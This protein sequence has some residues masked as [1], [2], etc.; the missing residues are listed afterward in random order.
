[1]VSLPFCHS[2]LKAAKP[3]VLGYPSELYTLGDHIRAA[4]LDRGLFQKDVAELAGVC[5]DTI[6]NWEK[7]RSNP[8]LRALPRVLEFLGYDPRQTEDSIASQLVAIRQAHGLSQR[9]LA[10]F[11]SIDPSTLSKWE[12][13][14][15]EP[16]GLYLQR[17]KRFLESLPADAQGTPS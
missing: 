1:M 13:G 12:L 7:N 16:H 4:R 15:R 6:T 10:Q 5:T 11:L 14:T 2:T 3:K 17:V 9:T 8:D